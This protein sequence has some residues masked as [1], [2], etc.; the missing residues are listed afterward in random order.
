MYLPPAFRI[1]EIA[2]QQDFVD[3]HPFALI[4]AVLGGT[5]EANHVPLRL[6]RGRG[7]FGTLRGHLAKANP[8]A[9][10]LAEAPAVLAVFQGPQGYVSPD[11]Y[12][13]E[14]QVP[15]WNYMAVHAA[16][17]IRPLPPEELPALLADLSA[18]HEERLRPKKPWTLDK[19]PDA[20][21]AAMLKGI[22]GFEIELTR[23]EGKFKLSQNKP[24]TDVAGAIQGLRG[25]GDE[26]AGELADAMA[27]AG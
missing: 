9:R 13:S 11:W 20:K 19:M 17:T 16:G 1:D 4:V 6:D 15:T 8:L 2:V 18:A 23:I 3:A 24:P 26:A 27:A 25:R 21:L 12:A 22:V 14:H 7:P 5:L 10:H